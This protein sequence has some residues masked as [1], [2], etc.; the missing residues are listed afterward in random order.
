MPFAK[1]GDVVHSEATSGF[2]NQ[3]KSLLINGLAALGDSLRPLH[4]RASV[5]GPSRGFPLNQKVLGSLV[6][7]PR[8]K[9]PSPPRVTKIW[10]TVGAV[11]NGAS[12][13]HSPPRVTQ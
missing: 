4:L 3:K 2:N 5:S 11:Q 10:C 13:D 1:R 9:L 12:T 6:A 7:V 8:F